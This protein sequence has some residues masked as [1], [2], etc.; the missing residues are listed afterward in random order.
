MRPQARLTFDNLKTTVEAAGGTLADVTRVL[1]YLIDENDFAPMNEV[2]RSFFDTPY[3]NRTTIK[4]A[5]LM[6]PGWPHRDRRPRAR[7]DVSPIAHPRPRC[8]KFSR[9]GCRRR[10]ALGLRPM[11]VDQR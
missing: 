5:G 2:Y 11:V 10:S 1:I 9:H 8:R 7:A 3:P 4:V 6:F